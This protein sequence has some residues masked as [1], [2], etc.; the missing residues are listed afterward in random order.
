[1]LLYICIYICQS[2]QSLRQPWMIKYLNQYLT[3]KTN[4]SPGVYWHAEC[5]WCDCGLCE[6]RLCWWNFMLNILYNG[7]KIHYNMSTPCYKDFSGIWGGAV[8]PWLVCRASPWIERS[9]LSPG[10]G[11][12]NMFISFLQDNPISVYYTDR[13]I[14]YYYHYQRMIMVTG[15]ILGQDTVK[16]PLYPGA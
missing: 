7:M 9:C 11:H 3:C 4:I 15:V 8:A 2:R 12:Y 14:L 10:Q 16:V 6:G 13:V 1:M 5:T